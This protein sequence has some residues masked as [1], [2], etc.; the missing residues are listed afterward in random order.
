MH[1]THTHWPYDISSTQTTTK[2]TKSR[3]NTLLNKTKRNKLRVNDTREEWRLSSRLFSWF[4]IALRIV[5]WQ[6]KKIMINTKMRIKHL[7]LYY[8]IRM[9]YISNGTSTWHWKEYSRPHQFDCGIMNQLFD[10][11][12]GHCLL[13]TYDIY[14][15]FFNAFAQSLVFGH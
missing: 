9:M 7:Y 3:K 11:L 14:L 12:N 10:L 13:F 6:V 1:D 2:K 5:N 4:N 8:I 15:V